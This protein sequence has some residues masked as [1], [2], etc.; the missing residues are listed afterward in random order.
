MTSDKMA[1]DEL[2]VPGLDDTSVADLICLWR[3]RL[4]DAHEAYS[5]TDQATMNSYLDAFIRGGGDAVEALV[6][7]GPWVQVSVSTPFDDALAHRLQAHVRQFVGALFSEALI[8]NF[9]F[10][11]KPP[12]LRL[13]FEATGAVLALTSLIK[14]QVSSW[15]AE[16][17]VD[18]E[19]Y[20]VYEPESSLFGGARSMGHVHALFTLDSLVWLEYHSYLATRRD[21]D[22]DAWSV[23]F[24]ILRSLFDGLGIVGW[25]D[26]GVWEHIIERT[27]RQLP[28]DVATL[29]DYSSLESAVLNA[30]EGD[31]DW[32]SQVGP[33]LRQDSVLATCHDSIRA[34]AARWKADYFDSANAWIGPR[35]AAAYFT[36]FHWN[37]GRFSGPQQALIAG[38]L[39]RRRS[40]DAKGS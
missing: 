37:R 1:N 19:L 10:M 29:P 23:S 6:R 31:M 39:A 8:E 36:I 13:R 11:F 34:A 40:E 16:G 38:I 5:L 3:E 18:M 25:E 9:F 32:I 21:T 22:I 35:Q 28:T 12:G 17:L 24:T 20:G 7:R 27:G 30:W 33:R 15:R 4:G 26:L 2:A 14:S